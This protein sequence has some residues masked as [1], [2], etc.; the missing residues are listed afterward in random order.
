MVAGQYNG[1]RMKA[2]A[3]IL[4]ALALILSIVATVSLLNASLYRGI[5]TSCTENGCETVETTQTLV[6]MNGSWVVYQLG[7]VILI[8]GLPLFALMFRR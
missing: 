3:A 8:S 5:E 2:V 6:E 7:V 1:K 4:C